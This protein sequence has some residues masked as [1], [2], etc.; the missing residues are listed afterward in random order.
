MDVNGLKFCS[1]HNHSEM[2]N[3]RLSDCCIRISQLI[4]YACE[5]GLNGVCITD[6]EALSG[7]VQFLR[8]YHELKSI[9]QRYQKLKDAND[10]AG[11]LADEDIQKNLKQIEHM[12]EDFRVGL[13]NEIYLVDGVEEAKVT[14]KYFHFILIAK[15]EVGYQ[16]LKTISS[17]SAW[18]NWFK[19]HGVE[20]V[21]TVKSELEEII[22]N[23][24]GHIIAQTAC[25]GGEL[26]FD[27]LQYEK[28]GEAKARG[29]AD[30]FIKWCVNVFGEENFFLEIQPTIETPKESIEETH[31]QIVVN[32]AMFKLAEKYGLGVVVTTDSHYLRAEHKTIHAAFL[33][34]DNE[35]SRRSREQGDFYNTTYLMSKEEMY[36]LLSSHLSDDKIEKAFS[37]T[38]QVHSMLCDYELEK[39]VIVPEDRNIP[40]FTIQRVFKEYEEKYPYFKLFADSESVQDRYLLYL[41]ERGFL[42]KN[43]FE[44]T[45]A[46]VYKRD[47]KGAIVVD[48]N[49]EYVIDHYEHISADTK[50]ARINEELETFWL[51]SEKL[52]QR[53]SAYY[54]LVRGLVQE[55]MWKISY[56]GVSR[57]SVTG[58][59]IAYL[60]NIMQIDPLKYDL[61]F[62]RHLHVSRPELPDI[63]MDSEASK[64]Q[65]I[66]AAMKDYY[67][68]DN[69][70][71]TITFRT[72]SAKSCVQT[73]GRGLEINE[74][75][76]QHI[77][78][79][80]PFERGKNWTL[81]D[82][83]YG[84]EEL[85][86]APVSEFIS[87]VEKY[88]KLKE[89][90][91]L[92]EGL[93][94]G[95]GVHAS[96]A[97]CFTD[98]YLKQNT[99][100][101]AP[102]GVDITGYNM[103]D[104]EALSGLKID[105]LTILGADKL[106]KC[107]DLLVDDGLIEDKGSIQAT[108]NAALHPDVLKYNRNGMW[109]MLGRGELIDAFEFDTP[110]GSIAVKKTQPRTI[111]ELAAANSLMRLLPESGEESPI[112]VYVR[113]KD[114]IQFW[115]DDLYRAG[116]NNDE[117]KILEKYLLPVYGVA[118]TQ[119]VIMRLVQDPKIS[120]FDVAQANKLRKAI[121]KKKKKDLDAVK[122]L[123]FTKGKELGTTQALLDYV[124][125]KQIGRQ[126]GYS[127]SL[128]HT[129]PYSA[130]CLQ[131]MNLAYNFNPIYW[132]CACLTVNAGALEEVD[133]NKGVNYGMIATAISQAQ[134]RGQKIA[135]PD[136]NRARFGFYP[137]VAK[138]EIVCSFKGIVG[139]GEDVARVILANRPYTS[140]ADFMEKTQKST[141][142]NPEL[143]VGAVAII[144]LI[145]AG[146]FDTIEKRLREDVM[147]DYIRQISEPL[148]SLSVANIPLIKELGLVTPAQRAYE[149]RL[150]GFKKYVCSK[151]F[152]AFQKGK[153]VS[154]N[155]YRLDR[156]FGEPYFFEHFESE[157]QEGKDYE[158]DDGGFI[159]VKKGSIEKVVD[160]LTTDFKQ[161]VLGNPDILNAVNE[162]KFKQVLNDRAEGT[163]SR[164]EMETLSFYY[165]EHELANVKNVMYSI[166]N[167]FDLPEVPQI[168]S[169]FW[170]KGQQ[171]PRFKL[172]RI[173]GTILDKNKNRHSVTL[174]TPNGVVMVK[175]QKGQFPH[176]DKQLSQINEDGSK[177]VI[178]KSWFKRGNKLVITGYRREGQFVAKKYNDSIY[179]HT[180]ALVVNVNEDGTLDLQ[181]ERSQEGS[182]EDGTQ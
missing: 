39:D 107:V 142:E 43:E 97:F 26:D 163:I 152:Y 175:F 164:W 40:A 129:L 160:K 59:F 102:N 108:Y 157:M 46:E 130:I 27:I 77:S 75:E 159:C 96:A 115:Y 16:Q 58:C 90:M 21:P 78:D 162:W 104:S 25:L 128:N 30:T 114:N 56:V 12:P 41:I 81:D 179:K 113:Y 69:V 9:S 127:F 84:N 176:Y 144:S 121:A 119:E 92:L 23:D 138:E 145:K 155:Y 112:D 18:K 167:F 132:Q 88:D 94:V 13:G 45:L 51:I 168:E 154:T 177:T 140:F 172:T 11:I 182:A 105:V 14:G 141:D 170:Y 60:I 64:R 136:I 83:L 73:C 72:L 134:Y 174:L 111:S 17:K 151:E 55:I 86:R 68:Q 70:L 99:R 2:S 139:V 32:R 87:E 120:G 178:E 158:F 52:N 80:I 29:R 89:T 118:D 117:V 82:C 147:A 173:C 49:D 42:E 62:W 54:V 37:G 34:S 150:F 38:A 22:G 71:N 169:N 76:V 146:C 166:V 57:G 165:H 44:D 3:F 24:K 47:S 74:D 91:L 123:Y 122:E 35:D 66:F 161:N 101:K 5:L 171:R 61:P 156:K 6:H 135:L 95:R 125:I 53:L 110:M 10:E 15:D 143:K 93:I 31:D 126:I 124:W 19:F 48:E 79:L 149:C 28:H 131:E 7:H 133:E 33:N 180:V 181:N 106:H 4:D 116:L 148:S 1:N 36:K 20:R 85:S 67:G 50:I 65:E 153:S 8:R 137:D 103:G 98:G 109:K 100:M 63:D